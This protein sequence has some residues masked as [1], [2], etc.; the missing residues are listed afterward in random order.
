MAYASLLV[1]RRGE[2]HRL[3]G[4]AIEE[5]YAD[6][7]PEHYEV[8]AYH[9]SRT[10]DPERALTYLVRAAQKATQA[11]GLRQAIDLY[12]E[13]LSAAARLGD[14]VPTATLIGIHSARAD[15]LFGVG[16]FP[17]SREAAET[18]V[19]LARRAPDR[20]AEANALIQAASALQWAEDL[21]AALERAREAIELAEA[22]GA[23]RPLAGGLYVRG[24]IH[25][26]SG[27]LD[28]A[29]DDVERSLAIGRT[30]GDP[31]RQA[32]ALHL[33]ALRSG[34]RGD[35]REGLEQATEGV[36]LARDHALV[37]PL[38]RC[39]WNQGAAWNDLGEYDAAFAALSEG[40]ALA[41][42]IGD[43]AF[44]PRFQNTLGW[45][46]LECDALDRGME[47]SEL[48][49]EVTNRSSRAGHGTGAERRAFIRN[50]EADAFMTRGD[51]ASATEALAESHAIVRH[52]PPSRWMTWRYATHCYASQ[53]QLALRQGDPAR[54]GRLADREPRARG[55]DRL[56][57]VRGVGPGGSRGRARRC[58]VPGARRRRRCGARW[59]TRPRSASRARRGSATWRSGG[60]TRRGVGGT[61]RS[62]GTARRGLSS[63]RCAPRLAIPACGRGSSPRRS[64]G[65]SSP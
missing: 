57:K 26:V 35:Y 12:D 60:S 7:L 30:V 40:L 34:W 15:L 21:P 31:N 13:A 54:A 23:Q 17:R 8:L 24:Y 29:K 52:P 11:F 56:P 46:L 48:S 37:I 43:D 10:D 5:L 36:H 9:F 28:P 45:M 20:P 59:R 1:Q 47:L 55:A 42:R 44:I 33:L 2:L 25:M 49:Y 65:K 4:L 27:N 16:N 3:V 38:L 50:N 41:E 19:A 22:A 51:L 61:T 39:L 63:A 53:G 14:R 6:R 18:V 62:R 32:L 58:A 64:P